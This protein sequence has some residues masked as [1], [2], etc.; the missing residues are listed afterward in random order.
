MQSRVWAAQA[1]SFNCWWNAASLRKIPLE[2]Q[3]SLRKKIR[4]EAEKVTECLAELKLYTMTNLITVEKA[5]ADLEKL[6]PSGKKL[7]PT[8]TTPFGQHQD[9]NVLVAGAKSGWPERFNDTLPVRLASQ[10]SPDAPT[11]V[12]SSEEWLKDERIKSISRPVL[13]LLRELESP[14]SKGGLNPYEAVNDMNNTQGWFPLFLEWELEYYHVPFERW[15][16]ENDDGTCNWRYT[17]P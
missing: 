1:A 4:L 15:E 3:E 17:L 2:E 7:I 6:L 8:P 16:L 14:S 11:A 13:A 9:P 5:K 12:T 10:V